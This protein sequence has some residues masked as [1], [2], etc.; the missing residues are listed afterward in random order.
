MAL[1]F[2]WD[3]AGRDRPEK[4]RESTKLND[5]QEKGGRKIYSLKS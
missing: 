5:K 4:E 2:N 1:S 3:C